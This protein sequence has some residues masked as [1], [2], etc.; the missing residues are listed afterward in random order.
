[1]KIDVALMGFTHYVSPKMLSQHGF[2]SS[3]FAYYDDSLRHLS[4]RF[5][6]VAEV[7]VEELE[8]DVAVLKL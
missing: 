6:G 4:R 7:L 1:V 2:A 5:C 3:Y 8:L